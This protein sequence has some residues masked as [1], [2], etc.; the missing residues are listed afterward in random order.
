[1]RGKDLNITP[2]EA[3]KIRLELRGG[4]ADC[5]APL[6]FRKQREIEDALPHLRLAPMNKIGKVGHTDGVDLLARQKYVKN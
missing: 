1:M 3:D 5:M 4:I 6:G 2:G